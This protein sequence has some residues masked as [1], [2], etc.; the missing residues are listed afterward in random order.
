MLSWVQKFNPYDLYSKS[1]ERP[2]LEEVKPFYLD[3]INEFFPEKLR[4]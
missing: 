4:W 2:N 3:L 1:A